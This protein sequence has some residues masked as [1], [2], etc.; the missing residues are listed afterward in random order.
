MS[1]MGQRAFGRLCVAVSAALFAVG[2]GGSSKPVATPVSQPETTHAKVATA[3][4]TNAPAA[5]KAGA[6][7]APPL[8]RVRLLS[9]GA[10]PRQKLRYRYSMGPSQWIQMDMKMS[11]GVALNGGTV[12]PTQLPTMRSVCRIDPKSVSPEGDLRYDFEM[13][14]VTLLRDVPFP[15]QQ[16]E[17]IEKDLGKLAGSKGHAL[18]TA[19]GFT[20]E[21]DL[22]MPPD[23]PESVQDAMEN[24]RSALRQLSAP[25]PEEE[26]G[27]G[28]MWEVATDIVTPAFRMTQT[29]TYTLRELRSNGFISTV[30]LIQN[31]PKQVMKL[32]QAPD[33]KVELESLLSTGDG[34]VDQPFDRLVS[35]S[36]VKSSTNMQMSIATPD[37]PNTRM[38]MTMGIEM[39]FQP[40]RGP[41]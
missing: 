23:A 10:P 14:K 4:D 21:A 17:K 39:L 19:R 31:A 40:A 11:T 35:N 13:T 2:C 5:E 16:R 15:A 9:P 28:A 38:V 36:S 27:T 22:V 34:K 29:A 18:V 1:M 6:P 25:L 30:S 32:K 7:E 8:P 24:M 41:R 12:L 37:E 33:A 3:T 20:K 26:M